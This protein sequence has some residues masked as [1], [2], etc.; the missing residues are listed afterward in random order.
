M[1]A[2]HARIDPVQIL[3]KPIHPFSPNDPH[4]KFQI[5]FFLPTI[6]VIGE[7]RFY[8]MIAGTSTLTLMLLCGKMLPP[9]T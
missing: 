4:P 1:H 8:M 6:D 3:P 2:G 7:R 9:F 5:H